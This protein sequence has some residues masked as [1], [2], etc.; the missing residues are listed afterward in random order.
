MV[1]A[2]TWNIYDKANNSLWRSWQWLLLLAFAHKVSI[3]E[4]HL[5]PQPPHKICLHSVEKTS[6]YTVQLLF[7]ALN[8]DPIPVKEDQWLYW[9]KK[10]L[11]ISDSMLSPYFRDKYTWEGE[12]RRE[13][14]RG[15]HPT[16]WGAKLRL[17]STWTCDK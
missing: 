14:R 3:V 8:E 1:C 7:M 10:F 12:E 9:Y 16:S 5:S 17:W 13:K 15:F 4:H 2:N 6:C 11:R